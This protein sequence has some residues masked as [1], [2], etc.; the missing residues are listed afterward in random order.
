MINMIMKKRKAVI[1]LCA[2]YVLIM[3]G[4]CI[5]KHI[6]TNDSNTSHKTDIIDI[7]REKPVTQV[8][9]AGNGR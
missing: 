9:F 5:G 8:S 4:V 7:A 1:F 6:V 3:T 2:F